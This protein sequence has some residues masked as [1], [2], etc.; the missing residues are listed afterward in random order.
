MLPHQ[1]ASFRPLPII[2]AALYCLKLF[3]LIHRLRPKDCFLHLVAVCLCKQLEQDF[4]YI[5]RPIWIMELVVEPSF[6][7]RMP[8]PALFSAYAILCAGTG[9][10]DKEAG[11]VPQ[12]FGLVSLSRLLLPPDCRT[13]FVLPLALPFSLPMGLSNSSNLQKG[14]HGLTDIPALFRRKKDIAS[15]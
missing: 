4:S 3:F 9:F 7:P 6:I 2:L 15:G 8:P 10:H 12:A 11:Q 5:L 1:A 13:I 14:F